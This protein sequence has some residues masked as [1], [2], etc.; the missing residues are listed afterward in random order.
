MQQ[1][2]NK[3]KADK[4]GV[5]RLPSLI[6]VLELGRVIATKISN[7]TAERSHE[8]CL[9]RRRVGDP[10]PILL[11][12]KDLAQLFSTPSAMDDLL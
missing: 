4:I 8:K 1:E 9:R 5:Y 10:M 2:L 7:P 12:E 11:G 6:P 3:E